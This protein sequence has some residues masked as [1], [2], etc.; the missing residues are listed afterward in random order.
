MWLPNSQSRSV[1]LIRKN[2]LHDKINNFCI[3]MGIIVYVYFYKAAFYTN[4]RILKEKDFSYISINLTF[5]MFV[6]SL[7]IIFY[8]ISDIFNTLVFLRKSTFICYL[9]MYFDDRMLFLCDRKCSLYWIFIEL[10]LT[11]TA[12]FRFLVL[13]LSKQKYWNRKYLTLKYQIWL[14]NEAKH[15]WIHN[16]LGILY[17]TL[18]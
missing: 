6:H 1:L 18:S 11:D 15:V 5:C 9:K 17:G 7:F 4:G 2:N 8:Q 10:R 14:F 13:F 3:R 16:H 12:W